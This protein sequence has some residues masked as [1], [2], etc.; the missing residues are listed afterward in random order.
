MGLRGLLCLKL[1]GSRSRHRRDPGYTGLSPVRVYSR[2]RSSLVLDEGPGHWRISS[3]LGPP[4]GTDLGGGVGRRLGKAIHSLR[5]AISRLSVGCVCQAN[6]SPLQFLPKLS[7]NLRPPTMT[8]PLSA[9]C[10][11]YLVFSPTLPTVAV[12]VSWV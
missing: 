6:S 7:R 12:S 1:S 10:S 2:P 8:R 11:I 4:S 3:D 9:H 5:E